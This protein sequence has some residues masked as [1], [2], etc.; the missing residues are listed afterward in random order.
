MIRGRKELT[1][2]L[3]GFVTMIGSS[4]EGDPAESV[5]SAA[6]TRSIA[7]DLPD[8]WVLVSVDLP[9]VEAL[10][11]EL[12]RL[13][14]HATVKANAPTY[15]LRRLGRDGVVIESV[16][17][18][19]TTIEL[20]GVAMVRGE[21]QDASAQLLLA[22][23][24][25]DGLGHARDHFGDSAY[26]AGTDEAR[27]AEAKWDALDSEIERELRAAWTRITKSQK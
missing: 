26:V 13:R 6:V 16:V 11:E 2:A 24:Y 14:F 21:A 19:G 4:C 1:I 18:P 23:A 22:A 9:V 20:N 12:V 7:A 8:P 15:R 17:E 25:F 10:N 27:S 3:L 5:A